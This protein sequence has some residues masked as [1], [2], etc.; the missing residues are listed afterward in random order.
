MEIANHEILWYVFIGLFGFFIG[1]ST[2]G[3]CRVIIGAIYV[4]CI[5]LFGNKIM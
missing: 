4:G 5:L 2:H 3:V 1:I